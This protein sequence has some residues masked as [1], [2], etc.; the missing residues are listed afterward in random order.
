[1]LLAFLQ[2]LDGEPDLL[3]GLVHG[4]V[5]EVG[6]AGVDAQHRLGDAQFVLAGPGLVVDEGVRDVR[7]AVVAG[8]EVDRLLA[9]LVGAL[10]GDRALFLEVFAEGFGALRDLLDRLAGQHEHRARGDRAG[11]VLPDGVRVQQRL[12]AEVRAVSEDSED[13]VVAVGASADLLH[14][15]VRQQE[16]LVGPAAELGDHGPGAELPLLAA[17]SQFGE[18]VL[19][20]VGPQCGQLAQLRGDHL[21]AVA[22]LHERHPAVSDRVGQSPVHPVRTALHVHPGKHAQ[23]P[24][25]ADLLHLGCGLGGGGQVPR[26]RR[27]EALLRL[28]LLC[29]DLFAYRHKE[30][31]SRSYAAACAPRID[32]HGPAFHHG[33]CRCYYTKE[34]GWITLDWADDRFL[35]DRGRAR[36]ERNDIV[37]IGSH[38]ARRGCADRGGSGTSAVEAAAQGGR[39]TARRSRSWPH[40]CP[41]A[42]SWQL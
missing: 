31:P 28:V 8:R 33:A 11:R 32:L 12:V 38:P 14:P 1:M 20:S 22:G 30:L 5:V 3:L 23:Q 34:R 18:H 39:R 26:G 10:R 21:D 24:A 29:A 40:P 7:L 27:A 4:L 37:R 36:G 35:S 2:R 16:D 41:R 6:H 9:E 17:P 13:R 25:G 15:A 19:V 42:V